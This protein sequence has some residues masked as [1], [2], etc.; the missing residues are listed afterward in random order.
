MLLC[1]REKQRPMPLVP[2]INRSNKI[3]RILGCQAEFELGRCFFDPRQGDQQR[4]ID[5]FC[6]LPTG[7]H[8]D[9]PDAW[10]MARRL[11]DDAERRQRARQH[12]EP[13]MPTRHELMTAAM[14]PSDDWSPAT[15]PWNH[16]GNPM[17]WTALE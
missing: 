2:I 8:D 16:V 13:A 10:E 4:L 1:D 11:L 6:D 12:G 5:Q 9:G 7:K 17:I 14:E 3:D 15:D